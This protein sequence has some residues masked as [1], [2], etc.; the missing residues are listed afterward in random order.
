M[1]MGRCAVRSSGGAVVRFR[2]FPVGRHRIEK[3]HVRILGQCFLQRVA[4]FL[5]KGH[6]VPVLFE[7]LQQ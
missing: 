3:E 1:R 2:L 5:G 7:Q 6:L 4:P